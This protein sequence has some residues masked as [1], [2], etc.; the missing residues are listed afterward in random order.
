MS[1]DHISSIGPALRDHADFAGAERGVVDAKK[2][3]FIDVQ[4]YGV[5]IGNGGDQII[6]IGTSVDQ[7]AIA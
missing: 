1:I 2:I 6:L 4:I 7:C 5:I 3:F